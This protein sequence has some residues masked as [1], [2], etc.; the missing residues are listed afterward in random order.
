MSLAQYVES[1][2]VGIDLERFDFLVPLISGILIVL[3]IG[4]TF[5]ALLSVFN[6]LFT[7]R[8]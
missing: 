5:R 4:I 7:I 6:T 1:L 2:L 3:C 8:K